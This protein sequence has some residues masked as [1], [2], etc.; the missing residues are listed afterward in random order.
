MRAYSPQLIH[1][2]AV[3]CRWLLAI[4]MLS[5]GVPKLFEMSRFTETVAAFGLIPD[6]LVTPVALCI[7]ILELAAGIGLLLQKR[8]ALLLTTALM[9]VFIVVLTYGI[10]LGLDIDC[11]CFGPE[12]PG[13]QIFSSL[14][15]AL[16]RD[17]LLLLPLVYLFLQPFFISLLPK[18]VS[19]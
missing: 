1:Y 2:K 14:K 8:W 7:V 10:W 17:L 19:R 3:A 9:G 15:K 12:D 6:P 18:G 4:V 13:A 11:G 16:F 5:A